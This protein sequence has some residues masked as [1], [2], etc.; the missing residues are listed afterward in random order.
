MFEPS[1]VLQALLALHRPSL[2]QWVEGD[3]HNNLSLPLLDS[4][5]QASVVQAS[6]LQECQIADEWC[7]VPSAAHVR[8]QCRHTSVKV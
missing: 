4:Q 1:P 7:H 2:S 6:D 8:P 3:L 5:A